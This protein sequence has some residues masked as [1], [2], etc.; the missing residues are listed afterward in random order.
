MGDTHSSDSDFDWARLE[1]QNP[2]PPAKNAGRVRHPFYLPKFPNRV[3]LS[4][5]ESFALRTTRRSRRTPAPASAAVTP[6]GILS[7]PR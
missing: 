4:A 1:S 3:I 5:G 2:H 7:T 6:R